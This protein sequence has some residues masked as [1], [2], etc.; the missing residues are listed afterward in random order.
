M[1]IGWISGFFRMLRKRPKLKIRTI[2]GATFYSTILIDKKYKNLQVHKTAF[3]LYLEITNTGNAPS[4]I[5]E[6]KIGYLPDNKLPSW[7]IR[8]SWI[9]ETVLKSQLIAKFRNSELVKSF[10]F[11]KQKGNGDSNNID[12][13]L[14][15]G[16]IVNGIAYFE[17]LETY[18]NWTPRLDKSKNATEI[19]I[20]I[21]DAF[22]RNHKKRLTIKR[23]EPE[24]ALEMSPYFGQTYEEYAIQ[25][26]EID[27]NNQKPSG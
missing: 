21:K 24:K 2:E 23:I 19:K 10:P 15:I 16:K 25:N 22:G 12:T 4:S 17:E 9:Y 5:G 8:R 20:C 27:K 11:L 6:I 13:Y 14:E 7:A 18:G 1:I 26:N 3:I